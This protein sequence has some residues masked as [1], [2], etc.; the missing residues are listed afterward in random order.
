MILSEARK[1]AVGS[2]GAAGV[3]GRSLDEEVFVALAVDYAF[4]RNDAFNGSPNV[5]LR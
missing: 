5:A 3:R 4:G 1:L 2:G